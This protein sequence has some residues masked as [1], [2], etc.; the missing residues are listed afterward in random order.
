[1]LSLVF[2]A[3]VSHSISEVASLRKKLSSSCLLCQC[4]ILRRVCFANPPAHGVKAVVGVG[5][6]WVWEG[7][8]G[9]LRYYSSLAGWNSVQLYQG[10][11]KSNTVMN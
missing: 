4:F 9:S 5:C 1:M 8:A 3:L 7:A 11:A 6:V 2:D 10:K